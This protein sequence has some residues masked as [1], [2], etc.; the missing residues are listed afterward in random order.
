MKYYSGPTALFD[1]EPSGSLY[2]Q[3]LDQSIQIWE[4]SNYDNDQSGATKLTKEQADEIKAR[5]GWEEA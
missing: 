5:P 1:P 4:A 3:S 2:A